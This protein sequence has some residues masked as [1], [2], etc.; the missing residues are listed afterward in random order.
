MASRVTS[1]I[2][3]RRDNIPRSKYISRTLQNT[4][5]KKRKLAEKKT[6]TGISIKNNRSQNL[7]DSILDRP[8]NQASL[9][10]HP[11]SHEKI[12]RDLVNSIC[13]AYGC[14]NRAT[15]QIEVQVGK[16]GSIPLNLCIAC[17]SLF[18]VNQDKN[19]EL[20][21]NSKEMTGGII[22]QS[23]EEGWSNLC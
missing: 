16:L 20:S 13:E 19:R 22:H 4:C 1:R 17:V 14:D 7:P 18:E 3:T 15:T 10:V 6:A 11:E 5:P 21:N 12:V 2:D 9:G 8:Y 23:T